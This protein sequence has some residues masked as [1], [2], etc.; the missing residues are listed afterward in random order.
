M[1][2]C[3]PCYLC[4]QDTRCVFIL[5]V[6]PHGLAFYS[7]KTFGFFW[8][9]LRN[10]FFSQLIATFPRCICCLSYFSWHFL[11]NWTSAHVRIDTFNG[12]CSCIQLSSALHKKF[13]IWFVSW[14]G[15]MNAFYR[16]EQFTVYI[17]SLQ[18]SS[19]SGSGRM[20]EHSH[21]CET[22]IMSYHVIPR[23]LVT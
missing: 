18:F 4:K 16:H 19:W 9:G 13:C 20:I 5:L 23:I 17:N 12:L 7:L 14:T 15:T 21:V 8:D 3:Y 22:Q 11:N 2:W 6:E 10:C 1:Q